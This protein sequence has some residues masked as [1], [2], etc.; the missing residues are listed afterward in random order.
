MNLTTEQAEAIG[1]AAGNLQLIACAGS[2][3]TEVVAQHITRLLTPKA[4]GGMGLKPANIVA[5]TFTEKASAELKQ[6]VLDRCRERL[7]GLVGM[8]EM[9]IGTIHG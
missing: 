7:P 1:H 8:A 9:Y 6:R 5:F 2:G 4:E 3:K